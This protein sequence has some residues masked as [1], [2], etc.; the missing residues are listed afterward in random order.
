MEDELVSLNDDNH[1][2]VRYLGWTTINT[3]VWDFQNQVIS[4]D[5]SFNHLPTLPEEIGKLRRL[6]TLNCQNNEISILPYSIGRL[7]ALK[8]LVLSHNRLKTVPDSIGKCSNLTALYLNDNQLQALSPALKDCSN[9]KKLKLNNNDLLELPL[10]IALLD[11]CLKQIDLSNNKNLAIIPHKVQSNTP[12]IKWI[13]TFRYERMKEIMVI[14]TAM[15]DLG[16]A[17]K[18]AKEQID[19]TTIELQELK[20]RRKELINERERIWMYLQFQDIVGRVHH[21]LQTIIIQI[22]RFFEKDNAKITP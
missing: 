10:S 9:L 6:S 18:Y 21:Q 15:K 8:V 4:L 11:D 5:L 3:T 7:R 13:V 20:R 17:V 22:R 16:I 14:D 12:V 2:D 19:A 1:I